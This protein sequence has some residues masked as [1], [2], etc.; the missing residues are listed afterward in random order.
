MTKILAFAASTRSASF[1][2]AALEVAVQGAQEAGASVTTLMLREFPLPIYDQDAE[3]ADGLPEHVLTLRAHFAAH[4]GLLIAVPEYNG[5]FPPIYKNTL[6]W[7]S[8]PAPEDSP[9]PFA[10]KTA[11]V[12][13]ASPGGLGGMRGL[14]HAK[15]LLQNLGIFVLPQSHAVGSAHEVFSDKNFASSRHA[16]S[17]K[18]IGEALAETTA[19]LGRQDQL[20]SS[21]NPPAPTNNGAT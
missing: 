6:D 17:L 21:A 11:A 14:P 2:Q 1:N 7:L 16:S 8:R 9:A 13:S 10:N 3:A 4:D 18:S 15:H 5:F 19:K 20:P 12:I